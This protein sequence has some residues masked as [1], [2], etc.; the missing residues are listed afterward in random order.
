MQPHPT[1]H[2]GDERVIWGVALEC[3]CRVGHG[4]PTRCPGPKRR[5]WIASRGRHRGSE[6]R[7]RAVEERLAVLTALPSRPS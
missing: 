1:L 2:Q 3:R 5:K 7:E 6:W 4:T